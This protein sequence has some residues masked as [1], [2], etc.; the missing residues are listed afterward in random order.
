MCIG[1]GRVCK[2]KPRVTVYSGKVSEP[3]PITRKWQLALGSLG[4]LRMAKVHIT[5]LC[6]KG[7][8]FL[9]LDV[10]ECCKCECRCHAAGAKELA[11]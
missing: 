10:W 7:H 3:P 8:H 4:G 9:C 5:R 2:G 6:K 11:K 1:L